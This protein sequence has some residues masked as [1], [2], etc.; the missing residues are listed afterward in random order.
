MAKK[1]KFYAVKKG[2]KAGLY[3]T[4]DAAKQQVDGFAGAVYKSFLTKAEAEEWMATASRRATRKVSTQTPSTVTP[5]I[6]LYT[7]GGSRNTGNVRGG[8]VRKEDVAAWAF[9]IQKDGESIS[10]SN[11]EFGATN[12]RMEIMALINGLQKV[13]D[14]Y[15]EKAAVLVVADSKYVLDAIQRNWLSGW[16]RRGW[17]KA[18]GEIVANKELWQA[19]ASILKRMPNLEYRWTKGHATNEG[20]VFVDQLL[21]KTMDRMLR[22]PTEFEAPK[23]TVS[24]PKPSLAVQDSTADFEQLG[25]FHNQQISDD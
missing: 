8:H 4:W 9:L 12:N 16:Q 14:R 13:I 10:G 7:D 17:K 3:L 25:L 1:R 20:N 22:E 6:I 11:G 21:N 2:R 24:N 5:S 18:N 19:V 23:K 15:G